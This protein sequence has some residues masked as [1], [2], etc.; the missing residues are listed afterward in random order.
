MTQK[1]Y[2][3]AVQSADWFYEMSDDHRVWSRGNAQ[4]GKLKAEAKT[5]AIKDSMY[6]AWT[7]YHYSGEDFGKPK[8]PRPELSMWPDAV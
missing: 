8:A 2:F 3:H 7:A 1:E 4:F 6:K 5:D